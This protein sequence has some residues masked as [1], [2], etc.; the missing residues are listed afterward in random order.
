MFKTHPENPELAHISEYSVNEKTKYLVEH[1]EKIERIYSDELQ[2]LLELIK[3]EDER[4]KDH[5]EDSGYDYR[6][7][8]S[9]R[10]IEFIYLRMHRYSAILA[11]YT[12]LE[13]SMFKI[14]T[15]IEYTQK[16]SISVSDVK[17]KGIEKCK[18]YLIKMCG[19]DFM[20]INP[21]WSRVATLNKIR[22]C[23]M[24]GNGDAEKVHNS[25]KFIR[26]IESSK[27]I[28]FIE[29]KLIMVSEE[30]VLAS[31]KDIK[32]LLLFLVKHKALIAIRVHKPSDGIAQEIQ[33]NN[34]DSY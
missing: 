13:S 4:T 1:F 20:E 11:A 30:F 21:L 10:E 16:F 5:M 31:I 2:Q 9:L 32:E 24:H 22:N 8:D 34:P 29:Q 14:C 28:T 6:P 17:G 19:F 3:Q 15:Q 18:L 27:N 7:I 33:W 23:I 25:S 26:Q 12:Y